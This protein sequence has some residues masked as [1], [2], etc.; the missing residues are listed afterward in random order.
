MLEA[1]AAGELFLDWYCNVRL[2]RR[3]I[4]SKGNSRCKGP[5]A[6]LNLVCS[7]YSE[8]VTVSQRRESEMRMGW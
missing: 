5:E 1:R 7:R 3:G 4:S 2:I 6:G 8:R